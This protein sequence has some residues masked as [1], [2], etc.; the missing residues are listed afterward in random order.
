M[1]WEIIGGAMIIFGAGR[2]VWALVK[3]SSETAT[4]V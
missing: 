4:T 1:V 3:N 2:I